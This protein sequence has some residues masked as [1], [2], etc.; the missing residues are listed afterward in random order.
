MFRF[1]RGK[2]YRM[3]QTFSRKLGIM[4]LMI[5]IITQV[6]SQIPEFLLE[7]PFFS[8]T[9]LGSESLYLFVD[10]NRLSLMTPTIREEKLRPFSIDFIGPFKYHQKQ[11]YSLK[12]EPLAKAI[13]SFKDT[14]LVWDITCGTGSDALLFLFF[15]AKVVAFERNKVMWALLK[16]ALER[17][18]NDPEI[19][20]HFQERF[21]LIKGDPRD[22]ELSETPKALYYDP[23]YPQV[24]RKALPRKEMRVIREIVGDDSDFEET[25]KWAKGISASRFIVKRPLKSSPLNEKPGHI[26]EGKSTRYDVYFS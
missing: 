16:D 3:E 21:T 11:N 25:I 6:N 18:K 22:T 5:S 14:P 15:G 10:E 1:N 26:Y 7:D 17:A 2:S 19:G 13:G 20:H 23:M 24:K 9:E 8:A 12:K 4:R